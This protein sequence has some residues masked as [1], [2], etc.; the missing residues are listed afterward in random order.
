[1]SEKNYLALNK[2][3]WNKRTAHHVT[4]DFYAMDDFKAGKSS[5]MDIE[6]GL[7][8][9]I[10]GKRILHL[11]CHFG[12]DSLS[13]ASNLYMFWTLLVKPNI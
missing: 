5:L 9:D 11:Q 13:L 3:S 4:S 10:K 7:L 1:M 2:E 12:Q 6:L 8:G